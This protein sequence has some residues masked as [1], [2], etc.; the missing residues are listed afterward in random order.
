M[1][2]VSTRCTSRRRTAKAKRARWRSRASLP[3]ISTR[4]GLP[5]ANTSR[6][7]TINWTCGTLRWPRKNSPKS[8]KHIAFS[9][10]QLD[11]WDVEVA[12][13]KL[14]KVDTDYSY[15]LNRD[16]TWS[17]DSKWIAFVKSLPNRL[18]AVS[19]YSLSDGKSTQVT[20]GL[21]DARYPVFDKDGQYLYF[22][23]STNFGPTSSGLDMNSDLHEV[24]RNVYLIVLPND[25]ASPLA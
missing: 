2:R 7:A 5:T 19:M 11:L 16:F 6:L 15:E 4:A 22:T 12:S 20:D 21:S 8:S 25:V 17:P 18:H 1:N 10:N 23:A 24:T 3:F 9:D 13:E 14:T